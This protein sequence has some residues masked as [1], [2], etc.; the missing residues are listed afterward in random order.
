M[1][2]WLIN[3]R[4]RKGLSQTELAKR[5]GISQPSYCAIEKSKTTPR[6]ATAKRIA[7]E[8]GFDWTKFFNDKGA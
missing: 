6:P 7:H 8:L 1:R 3:C 2:N 4:K 5:A